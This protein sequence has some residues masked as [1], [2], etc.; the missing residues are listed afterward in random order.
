[1]RAYSEW[2][3]ELKKKQSWYINGREEPREDVDLVKIGF[4][5]QEVKEAIGDV[6]A[7]IH[8]I[9]GDDADGKQS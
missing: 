3:E 1:M 4:I 8:I 2:D 5:A 9:K 7:N 6:D